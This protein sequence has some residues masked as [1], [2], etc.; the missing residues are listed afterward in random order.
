MSIRVAAAAAAVVATLVVGCNV[1][2]V[3]GILSDAGSPDS[4]PTVC[5]D[6]S[7]KPSCAG[8]IECSAR[9]DGGDCSYHCEGDCTPTCPADPCQLECG[10]ADG[11]QVDCQVVCTGGRV[12]AVLDC[13]EDNCT[14]GCGTPVE[15][16]GGCP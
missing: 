13:R 3:V 10:A 7:C 16:D 14:V 2:Q 5:P 1:N 12:C 9:C 4:G 8:Q 6:Y 11:G 15:A